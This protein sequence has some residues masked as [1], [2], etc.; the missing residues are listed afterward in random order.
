LQNT[1]KHFFILPQK[2]ADF[3]GIFKIYR[4]IS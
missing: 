3:V 2:D 1:K 4:E